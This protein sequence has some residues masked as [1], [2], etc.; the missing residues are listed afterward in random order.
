LETL[1]NTYVFKNTG[2]YKEGSRLSFGPDLHLGQDL[3]GRDPRHGR[4]LIL[5]ARMRFV[6]GVPQEV[7]VLDGGPTG[8]SGVA[9]LQVDFVGSLGTSVDEVRERLFHVD[10]GGFLLPSNDSEV[11]IRRDCRRSHVG[12]ARRGVGMRG[13]C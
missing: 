12:E 10:L 2:T 13:S 7:P 11:G 4:G 5:V 3:Q 8:A 1:E 6:G 9:A